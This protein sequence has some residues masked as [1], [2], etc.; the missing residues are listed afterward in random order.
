MFKQ[1]LAFTRTSIS[2]LSLT[3]ALA[4]TACGP[5]GLTGGDNKAPVVASVEVVERDVEAPEV[6][7][8]SE[9]A[10]WDGRPSLGGIWVAH[11]DVKDP[12]RV[13]IRNKK[14]GKFVIGAL[15]RRDR[16]N[17]GPRLQLSSDAADAL[18]ILAGQP[19]NV[20]VTALR[21]EAV[22]TETEANT[23]AVDA[24]IDVAEAPLDPVVSTAAAALSTAENKKTPPVKDET[25]SAPKPKAST[26]AKP[27]IQ[28]GIFGVEQNA[29]NTAQAMRQRGIIPLIKELKMN[30]KTF[31]RVIVGP[32]A[33][34]DE[35]KDLSGKV[36]KAG[37]S[38]AYAV[39]G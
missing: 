37:F 31:W 38:D 14:N 13:I 11:P 15:F 6:F 33:T 28:I 9:A 24:P 16:E 5:T 23:D 3:V 36:K 26:L 8:L 21:R 29:N 34:S 35:L 22:K 1:K 39:S 2:V 7:D 30:G 27:Y 10:L 12:E 32:A 25:K 20:S 17:V 19:T 18:G 4:I